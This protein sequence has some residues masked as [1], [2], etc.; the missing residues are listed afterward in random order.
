MYLTSNIDIVQ[1]N[2]KSGVDTYY[3]PKNV[4]WR[5]RVIDKIV[6]VASPNSSLTVLS[7]IDG[8]TQLLGNI[9]DLYFDLYAADD[10]LI[11]RNLAYENLLYLNNHILPIGQKLSLNLSRLHFTTAPEQD[12]CILLYFY[13]GGK[14]VGETEPARKSVT[15]TVP[16]KANARVSLQDIVDNYIYIQPDTVKGVYFWD[17]K[18]K[19]VYLTLRYADNIHVLNSVLSSLCRPPLDEN[20]TTQ[21]VLNLLQSPVR[22]PQQNVAVQQISGLVQIHPLLLDNIDV[23]MLNSFVQNGQNV[24]VEVKLTF[25]Y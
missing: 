12:G 7:P 5:D 25:L 1:I 18:N 6:L 2:I 15:V 8:Q 19:P 9:T 17:S 22:A 10:S 14:E 4:N 21:S 20:M 24:D 13:Y 16:L 3:L 23:D 11:A